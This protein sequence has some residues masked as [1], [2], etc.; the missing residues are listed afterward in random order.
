MDKIQ[1]LKDFKK[2]YPKIYNYIKNWHN[3]LYMHQ[4][5]KFRFIKYNKINNRLDIY[6]A[7]NNNFNNIADFEINLKDYEEMIKNG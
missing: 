2:I 7:S 6:L 3:P 4:W 5:K 1:K